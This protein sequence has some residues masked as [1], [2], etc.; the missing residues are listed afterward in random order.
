MTFSTKENPPIDSNQKV[1]CPVVH[2][3]SIPFLFLV[4]SFR[5]VD[6]TFINGQ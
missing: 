3:W 1:V 2:T 5:G 6:Y 4:A